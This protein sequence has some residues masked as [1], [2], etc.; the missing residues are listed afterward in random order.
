MKTLITYI[1][2]EWLLSRVDPDMLCQ[3]ELCKV[4]LPTVR[5]Q[6]LKVLLMA[7]DVLLELHTIYLLATHITQ[8]CSLVCLLTAATA[9]IASHYKIYVP[10]VHF[11]FRA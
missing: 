10:V 7:T 3:A 5:T 1:T 6:M 8:E 4:L 2:S 11:M 9:P